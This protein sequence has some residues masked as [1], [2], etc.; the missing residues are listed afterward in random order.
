[1]IEFKAPRG[2]KKFRV[3]VSHGWKITAAPGW[4]FTVDEH[5]L[6]Q[7]MPGFWLKVREKIKNWISKSAA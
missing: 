1:M 7:H 2:R 4:Y 6:L 5:G 3:T